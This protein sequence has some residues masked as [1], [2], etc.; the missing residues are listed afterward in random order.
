MLKSL[1]TRVFLNLSNC[2]KFS[3][4]TKAMNSFRTKIDT[5]PIE[6]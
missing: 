2:A 4:Q 5:F 1:W 6:L 3:F